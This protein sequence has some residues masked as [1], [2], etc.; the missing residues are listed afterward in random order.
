MPKSMSRRFSDVDEPNPFDIRR[1]IGREI[2][3]SLSAEAL[4]ES[5]R[6]LV[7]VGGILIALVVWECGAWVVQRTAWWMAGVDHIALQWGVLVLKGRSTPSA[8]TQAHVGSHTRE[9]IGVFGLLGGLF[10]L[11]GGA[12]GG[13]I[14]RSFRRAA[15]AGVA[16]FGFGSI[17][18]GG[19]CLLIVPI[20]LGLIIRTPDPRISIAAHA[21][22]D[23]TAAAACG[24]AAGLAARSSGMDSLRLMT[25]GVT[26][27]SLGALLFG[28]VEISCFPFESEFTPIPRS[29][30]CRLIE[31]F[32]ATFFP[33]VCIAVILKAPPV[34]ATDGEDA[35]I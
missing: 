16:G 26:G 13:L 12:G 34:A 5:A 29:S 14:A 33:A 20:Y 28:I 25:A 3:K 9:M 2:L 22:I 7:I 27:A 21:A 11:L 4:G 35:T 18:C 10:G 15:K 17:I 8:L 23:S 1:L 19:L 24:L 30:L 32:C 6:V 31:Y